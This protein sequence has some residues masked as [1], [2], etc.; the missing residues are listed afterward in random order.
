MNSAATKIATTVRM[1]LAGITAL[2]VG[3]RGAVE[4]VARVRQDRVPVQPVVGGDQ[5]QTDGA[6]DG[7]VDARGGG[8]PRTACRGGADPEPAVEVVR[9][10]PGDARDHDA[11]R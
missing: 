5:Q 8:G 4:P 7:Q 2:H 11:P 1:P 10:Q 6:D 3:V 9:D